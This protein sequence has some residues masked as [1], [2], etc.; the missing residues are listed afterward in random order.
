[1]FNTAKT[2]MMLIVPCIARRVKGHS[3][4]ETFTFRADL[5][6]YFWN[7]NIADAVC[8]F[9]PYFSCVSSYPE[10]GGET[11]NSNTWKCKKC[12]NLAAFLFPQKAMI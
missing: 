10:A 8:I 12:L 1:M 5:Q 2:Y 6:T 7:H 4:K 11:I 9:H 3:G